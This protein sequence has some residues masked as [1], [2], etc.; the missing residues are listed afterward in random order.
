MG[1]RY[2]HLG[3]GWRLLRLDLGA[4]FG[5]VQH[6]FSWLSEKSLR[7]A[8]RTEARLDASDRESK[9]GREKQRHN[10]DV[11]DL[12]LDALERELRGED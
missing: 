7:K 1:L 10:E 11:R 2:R 3:R 9:L 8:G 4:L 6:F 12:D 5:A